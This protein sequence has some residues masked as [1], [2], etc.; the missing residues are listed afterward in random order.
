ML[1]RSL[2]H[3]LAV[4]SNATARFGLMLYELAC[5]DTKIVC[6]RSLAASGRAFGCADFRRRI[7]FLLRCL[8]VLQ[9]HRV[10]RVQCRLFE[11]ITLD[12]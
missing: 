1:A 6:A 2:G 7:M 5:A 3:R 8:L 9:A 11:C 10:H 4:S 12:V